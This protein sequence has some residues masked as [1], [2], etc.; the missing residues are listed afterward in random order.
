[1][2]QWRVLLAVLML[3]A[4]GIPAGHARNLVIFSQSGDAFQGRLTLKVFDIYKEHDRSLTILKGKV[5]GPFL[6]RHVSGLQHLEAPNVSPSLM[7]DTCMDISAFVEQVLTDPDTMGDVLEYVN[8]SLCKA[9]SGFQEECINLAKIYVPGLVETLQVYAA[10][11]KLCGETKLCPSSAMLLLNDARACKM[12]MEYATEALSY[13]QDSKTEEEIMNALHSQCAKLGDFSSRCDMLVDTYGP[14]YISKLDSTTPEQVC[15]KV[16]I[17]SAPSIKD[18]SNC[19]TCEFAV[20]QLKAKLRNPAV[21]D[22]MLEM[23]LDHCTKVPAHV[24]QCKEL[25]TQYGPLILANIDTY[26]DPKTICTEIHACDSKKKLSDDMLIQLPV[27][28][29]SIA[30]L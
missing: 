21:Q 8:G 11:D 5:V 16:G 24:D 7:C 3:L 9:L 18:P 26:V 20:Y 27:T 6:Q 1:M 23:L 25:V 17:C 2:S 22:K 10:P 4:L 12:C 14:I 13:A 15:Q 30:H 29:A 28:H 19:A